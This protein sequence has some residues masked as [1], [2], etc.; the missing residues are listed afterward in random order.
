MFAVFYLT[1]ICQSWKIDTR[2]SNNITPLTL[3]IAYIEFEYPQRHTDN[4]IIYSWV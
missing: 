2:A 4:L 1:L 3:M